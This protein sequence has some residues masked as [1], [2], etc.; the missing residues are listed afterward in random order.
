MKKIIVFIVIFT[1][2][3]SLSI[4]VTGSTVD[5]VRKQQ[6]IIR[7]PV[8]AE[9]TPIPGCLPPNFPG[10]SLQE[11]PRKIFP[12]H[13]I[14]LQSFSEE[15]IDM[16]QQLDGEMIL[17]YLEDLTAFGPRVTGN[18]ECE[19]AG[20]YIYNEFQSMGLDVRYQDWSYYGYDDRNIEATLHGTNETS[21]EI[22]IICGHYDSVPDSPGADDDGSGTVA[23][24]AAA[25]IMSQ[26]SFNHTIRFVT[27]SGEEQGLLGSHEYVEEASENGDNIIA[28]LNVDMIGYAITE[29]DGNNVK[30]YE[31][32]FS[33]WIT[34]FMDDISN[35]YYEYIELNVIP[36]G[37]SGG[38]D[39]YSFWEFGYS[40]TFSHEYEFN[41][42]YHTPQDII[43]NM[44][45]TYSTKCSKLALATL[46]ELAQTCIV[47][48][49]PDEP[50]IT[51]P[52][53]GNPEVEYDYTFVTTD[54][55][56]DRVY[57]NIEWG[58]GQTEEWFG[59]YDSG[60]EVI[61]SHIWA[62]MG[63]YTLKAKAKDTHNLESDWET[64]IVSMP[65]TKGYQNTL[66]LRFFE[67]F[68]NAFP[69]IRNILGL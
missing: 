19:E 41:Y 66:F 54:P 34:D 26:Y 68:P 27:F 57:Y 49:P 11:I 36:S 8:D 65:R 20:D 50:T 51:G 62:E 44:N 13:Q 38:S 58:D 22:Y 42:Y 63:T 17:G 12:H 4:P 21:D 7:Q 24:L 55:D 43:E 56:G 46:A 15:V 3:I 6:S 48:S 9:F 25:Y 32:G 45:I 31:N 64:L 23:V 47:S 28:V 35:Q 59:P 37:W 39:H 40:A 67:Q 33:E 60:E 2:L 30:V 52:A 1:L 10:F 5:P 14:G 18:I 53:K 29:Y 16:I 61:V 69:I